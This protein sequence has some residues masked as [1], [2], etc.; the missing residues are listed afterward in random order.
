MRLI[1][2]CE[3]R[4]LVPCAREGFPHYLPPRAPPPLLVWPQIRWRKET[5][6]ALESTRHAADQ[7]LRD[8]DMAVEAARLK[9]QMVRCFVP[10]GLPLYA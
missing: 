5:Q 6:L 7:L 4:V 9:A 8:R 1:M 10:L 2:L 3:S